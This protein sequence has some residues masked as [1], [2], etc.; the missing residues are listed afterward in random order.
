MNIFKSSRVLVTGATGLVGSWLI[1]DLIAKGADV[2]ALIFES[3]PTSE[4]VR[5]GDI[6]KVTKYYGDLANFELIADMVT[7]S[8]PDYIFH[9]GA[10][11]L[12]GNALSDPVRTF[13]SNIQGTWNVLEAVRLTHNGIKGVVV[14][15]SD[16]AY[17]SAKTLPYTEDF[18]L[19]GE[20][21]YDVSK[22]ATDLISQSYAKTYQLPVV[23]ARCGN[24]YGGG[25]LNWSRI[26]PGTIKT[27]LQNQQP[28]LRSSGLFIRDY[29]HV[30]DVTQAYLHLASAFSKRDLSGEAYNFSRDEPLSVLQIY[31]E[32][33]L[34]MT[35]E[36]IR[37]KILNNVKSE[38]QDQHLD[39]S[40][41]R[42]DLSWKSTVSL[43]L[44]LQKTIQWYKEYFDLNPV[45][46]K[47]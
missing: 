35:G 6:D 32:I 18:P 44:G 9:L 5:S 14:A 10:Q 34:K 8:K 3:S 15:S 16:K 33:C 26:V 7:Q 29:V 20:G 31:K 30:E 43:D 11:T 28:I 4:L 42:N 21:P 46:L 25:D 41:A 2:S 47:K 22:S 23:I 27:I 36:Y 40:K 1:K 13:R 17:G 24:I 12:V 38:I 37:P 19:H 45:E 39:S